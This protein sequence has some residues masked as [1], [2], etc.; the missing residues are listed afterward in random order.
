[1]AAGSVLVAAPAH[2]APPDQCLEDNPQSAL[3]LIEIDGFDVIIDINK[4]PEIT[5]YEDVTQDLVNLAR[6]LDDGVVTNRVACAVLLISNR[7]L[8]IDFGTGEFGYVSREFETG[9]ITIHGNDLVA[10]ATATSC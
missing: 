3:G 5:D 7:L 9:V 4:L 2:A 8:T 6:C 10:D 1:M